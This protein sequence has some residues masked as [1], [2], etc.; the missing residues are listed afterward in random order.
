MTKQD[1]EKVREAL[2]G[3][4]EYEHGLVDD[5]RLKSLRSKARAAKHL[6]K[7]ISPNAGAVPRR[8]SD[9]VTNPLLES[10]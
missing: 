5:I 2:Q 10:R 1:N 7:R 8:G 3:F 4:I 9:V 6:L